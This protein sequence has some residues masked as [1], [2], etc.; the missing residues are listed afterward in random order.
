MGASERVPK[1]WDNAFVSLHSHSGSLPSSS[2]TSATPPPC[3]YRFSLR[4]TDKFAQSMVGLP[5]FTSLWQSAERYMRMHHRG[6]GHGI[7]QVRDSCVQ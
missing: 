3:S 7:Q 1:I 4:W 5:G 6:V 2:P